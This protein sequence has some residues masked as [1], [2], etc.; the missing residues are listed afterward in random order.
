MLNLG[1]DAY[2]VDMDSDPVPGLH[3]AMWR[4]IKDSLPCSCF[5]WS[6]S[7]LVVP[8]SGQ[9]ADVDLFVVE[10]GQQHP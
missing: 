2:Y 9:T 8:V 3:E 4:L 5:Q 10:L 6:T 1:M 7:I